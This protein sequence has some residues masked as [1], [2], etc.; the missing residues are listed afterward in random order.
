MKTN[1]KSESFSFTRFKNV[2][3]W[4]AEANTM[5]MF[6]WLIGTLCCTIFIGIMSRWD[7]TTKCDILYGVLF[8][9][10]AAFISSTFLSILDKQKIRQQFLSL[11]ASFAEKYLAAISVLF[12][13]I[14]SILL[15]IFIGDLLSSGILRYMIIG[16]DFEL[17]LSSF[18]DSA[19][20]NV[21][22][23]YKI[24]NSVLLVSA[25][26]GMYVA[27]G[28]KYRKYTFLLGSMT[29]FYP[30]LRMVDSDDSFFLNQVSYFNVC[31]GFV[32]SIA[33]F[34][35]GYYYFKRIQLN[36]NKQNYTNGYE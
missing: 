17:I 19:D 13:K 5:N 4:Y 26:C 10:E 7:N 35:I 30:L 6:W 29:M 27:F 8:L 25:F 36:T 18:F 24:L 21:S 33:G 23:F 32:I 11:P 12:V 22:Y 28:A 9:A 1:Q 3:R 16:G 14:I 2:F 31:F 20:G 34:L 15:V